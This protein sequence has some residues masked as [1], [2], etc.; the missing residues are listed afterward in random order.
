MEIPNT[1]NILLEDG[2]QYIIDNN[3]LFLSE[4]DG[5]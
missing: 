3:L 1:Q 4:N 5:M 2:N